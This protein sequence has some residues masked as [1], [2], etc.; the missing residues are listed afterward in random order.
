MPASI[1]LPVTHVLEAVIPTPRPLYPLLAA[2]YAERPTPSCPRV[3]DRG[4]VRGSFDP[5]HRPEAEGV[6]SIRPCL[7]RVPPR[8]GAKVAYR[9]RGMR[10]AQIHLPTAK[11]DLLASLLAAR[12]PRAYPPRTPSLEVYR[13]RDVLC[14]HA[15]CRRQ[16]LLQPLP[17]A[18]LSRAFQR[19]IAIPPLKGRSG[20]HE[21]S[22]E[23]ASFVGAVKGTLN[24]ISRRS[25]WRPEILGGNSFSSI[26]VP[27]H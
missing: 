27:L 4:P 22:R 20:A 18:R 12:A 5:A 23:Q 26:G 11:H 6:P 8:P 9:L 10:R 3:G 15:S 25:A 7:R 1:L 19:Q 16:I 17:T 21:G 14:S 24:G 13:L 2:A